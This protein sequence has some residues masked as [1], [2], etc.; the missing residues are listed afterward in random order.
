MGL[1][2]D[3]KQA[4]TL[5]ACLTDADFRRLKETCLE[6]Q[7]AQ[8]QLLTAAD[9]MMTRCRDGCHGLCCRN[10]DLDAIISPWDLVY[11]LTLHPELQSQIAARAATPLGLYFA[12]CP[13]LKDGQGPCIFPANVRP[14]VCITSFCTPTTPINVE[15][16]RVKRRFFKLSWVGRW[17]Q[18]RRWL[19][20]LWRRLAV[21]RPASG[22]G[23]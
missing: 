21:H 13:F 12:D 22:P 11:I 2:A 14:E 4:C 17:A 7:A 6:I 20:A 5:L 23:S 16:R 3:L 9:G 18:T 15:L 10:V 19:L 1:N 8:G